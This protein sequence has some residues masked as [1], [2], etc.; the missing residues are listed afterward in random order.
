L[1]WPTTSSA[2][3]QEF[4]GGNTFG[5]TAF[6][7]YGGFWLSFAVIFTPTFNIIPAYVVGKD[8]H[9][10]LGYYLLGWA[11]F[12]GIMLL[13][14]LRT[15]IATTGVFAL[16]FLTFLALMIGAFSSST[17][18]DKIGGWLGIITAIVAWYTAMAGIVNSTKLVVKLPVGPMD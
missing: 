9:T 5:A 11:I 4:R 18:W 10:A 15:N 3:I 6:C 13:G 14:A 7:S 2:G 17:G 16:L 12:T 8:F 1:A